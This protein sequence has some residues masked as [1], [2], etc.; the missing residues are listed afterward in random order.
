MHE[1]HAIEAASRTAAERWQAVTIRDIG[2]R[3]SVDVRGT[4][5]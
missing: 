1:M 5:L 3:S 4:F 2:V